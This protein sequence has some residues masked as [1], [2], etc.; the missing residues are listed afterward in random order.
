MKQLNPWEKIITENNSERFLKIDQLRSII[1]SDGTREFYERINSTKVIKKYY[2]EF[3]LRQYLNPVTNTSFY[4][5]QIN[6][7]SLALPKFPILYEW[8]KVPKHLKCSHLK[9]E[10]L[11]A[12]NPSNCSCVFVLE[13][14]MND[15]VEIVLV[16]E[17]DLQLTS[18]PCMFFSFHI[19]FKTHFEYFYKILFIQKVHLHGMHFAVLSSEKLGAKI[20]L[21]QIK[22]MDEMGLLKRNFD[23]PLIKDT[24]IVKQ[25]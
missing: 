9:G 20:S 24:V 5:D 18:H 4:R 22:S 6:K 21:N 8:G 19:N 2:L 16:D 11:C 1:D 12:T 23:R 7:M 3:G 10:N 14:E 13:F 15:V 17:G 25:I